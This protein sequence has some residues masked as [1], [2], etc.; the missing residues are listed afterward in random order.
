MNDSFI[1]WEFFADLCNLLVVLL[2]EKQRKVSATAVLQGPIR[3]ITFSSPALPY[4][5][6]LSVC[7]SGLCP[8]Q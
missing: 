6:P 7:T 2:P 4:H 8:A 5:I 3:V 1:Y